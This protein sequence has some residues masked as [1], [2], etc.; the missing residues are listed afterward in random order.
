MTF[1]ETPRF[2]DN[3]AVYAKGGP[4]YS[5][6]VVVVNSGW[7]SRNINWQQ[8]RA[9]YDISQGMRT[10]AQAADVIAFFRAVKGM[11][12][13]F[14]FK[15]FNDYAATVSNGVLGTGVGTGYPTYQL[16]KNYVS[17]AF[18]ELRSISKPVSGTLTPYRNS[19]A[20]TAGTGAGQYSADTT[21]G[22]V[23]FVADANASAS[24]VAVGTTTNVTLA[25]NL[26]LVAG[27]LVYLNGFTGAN[28]SLLNGIA[29]TI[30]SISGAGP[31]VFVLA[32]NT[33]GATITVGSGKGYAYP[34]TSDAL[35][36]SFEFDVPVRFDTDDMK[37]GIGQDGLYTWE[38]VPIVEIRV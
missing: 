33:A 38:S 7:E 28:A 1:L 16:G 35:T 30:N 2:P 20:V 23:T 31:Y 34:Q 25:S 11:G 5:T 10:L 19:V 21:T 9:R 29:H 4:G 13:G 12:Y 27:K 8:S 32:T 18:S 26:S 37:G 22:V 6:T 15:D 17:G 36:A 24:N 3:V 14:R